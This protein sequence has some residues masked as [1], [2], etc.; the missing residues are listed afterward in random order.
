MITIVI[1]IDITGIDI[2]SGVAQTERI[3]NG[4]GKNGI[5]GRT[6]VSEKCCIAESFP[7]KSIQI[8]IIVNIYKVRCR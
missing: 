1:D 5:R 4:G 3:N 8:T 7:D 2:K 6:R